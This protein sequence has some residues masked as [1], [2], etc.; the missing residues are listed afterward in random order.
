MVLAWSLGLSATE[1]E[2]IFHVSTEIDKS[3]LY[4]YALTIT[5]ESD[6]FSLNYNETNKSFDSKI[7]RL[8]I[9]T[10]IPFSQSSIGFTY[11]LN[12]ITNTSECHGILSGDE[13]QT[14]FISLL[15]DGNTFTDGNPLT[16]QGLSIPDTNN[17]LS[18][19]N[20]LTLVSDPIN[21]IVQSCS[22]EIMIE[23]EL[24]L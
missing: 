1:I 11:N 3:N 8:F 21:D 24:S 18:A 20:T 22:G 5:P 4:G 15:I 6:D 19:E 10:D 14:G 23:A 17:N 13:T 12:L 16:N 2:K 7:I 9:N